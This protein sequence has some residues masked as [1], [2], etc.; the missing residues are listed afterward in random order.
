MWINSTT[1]KAMDFC[2]GFLI[3]PSTIRNNMFTE[4]LH[5]LPGTVLHL[6]KCILG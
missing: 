3:L 4:N 1:F 5:L 6:K 2:N